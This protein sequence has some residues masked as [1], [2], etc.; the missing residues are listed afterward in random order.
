MAVSPLLTNDAEEEPGELDDD[1]G[2]D[3]MTEEWDQDQ[4]RNMRQEW[5]VEDLDHEEPRPPQRPRYQ[6]WNPSSDRAAPS[7]PQVS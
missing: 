2:M 5:R 4:D 7:G 6:T 3:E 1:P